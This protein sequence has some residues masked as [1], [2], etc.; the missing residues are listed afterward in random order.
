MQSLLLP[1]D[2]DGLIDAI[3][4]PL[5]MVLWEM[6][7][8]K[9]RSSA[10]EMA[11][12]TGVALPTVLSS[13][14]RLA[15]AGLVVAQRA[16]KG[17]KSTTYRVAMPEIRIDNSALPPDEVDSLVRRYEEGQSDLFRRLTDD[18]PGSRAA[19][20]KRG[21]GMDWA[22]VTD[23]EGRRITALIRELFGVIFAAKDRHARTHPDGGP[24]AAT[25]ASSPY[26]LLFHIAPVTVPALP[27]ASVMFSRQ[28]AARADRL[29]DDGLK[30]AE[31]S[32]REL[33]VAEALVSGMTRPE[34]A[35]KLKISKYTV[36][37]LTHRIYRKLKVR[38]RAELARVM[39]S[40][41]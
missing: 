41:L 37:T 24:P 40:R 30:R 15:H 5:G 21:F 38:S 16:R 29:R 17:S 8:R 14:D 3:C 1:I 7:R 39:T 31:L 13:I 9:G 32:P 11:G 34:V 35:T 33:Q 23:E 22:Y 18:A 4:D 19:G 2:R 6:L 26:A 12:L 25:E 36:V 27:T 28:P 20:Q 10:A